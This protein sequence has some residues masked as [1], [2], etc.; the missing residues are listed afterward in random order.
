MLDRKRYIPALVIIIILFSF[1][2]RKR[3]IYDESI[4]WQIL[5]RYI[6]LTIVTV[7]S[8]A[9]HIKKAPKKIFS[10]I[11]LFYAFAFIS[12]LWSPN[13][14][15]SFAYLFGV[16]L[17]MVFIWTQLLI[18]KRDSLIYPDSIIISFFF[19]SIII[20]LV[21]YVGIVLIPDY[22]IWKD[23][24]LSFR[25]GGDLIH[26]NLL[27]AVAAFCIGF[28]LTF[29][30]YPLRKIKRISLLGLS[31]LTII[32]TQSRGALIAT[33]FALIYY[34]IK[35]KY[36]AKL[37][38]IGVFVVIVMFFYLDK[39]YEVFA[40]GQD[41]F[42]LT[43]RVYIW[44]LLFDDLSNIQDMIFGK[45]YAATRS[46]IVVTRFFTATHAHNLFISIFYQLGFIGSL[47]NFML[48]YRYC[49]MAKYNLMNSEFYLFN[50]IF[51][52]IYGIVANSYFQM[53][54]GYVS[55]MMIILFL[56]L[57]YTTFS[58]RK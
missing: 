10:Y 21:V 9:K 32:L 51:L 43:G 12:A 26:A 49:K 20:Q 47:I 5:L 33:I 53:Q 48:I 2:F 13:L 36:Y 29:R 1:S 19:A 45:G 7:I 15:I 23:G 57:S 18:V 4:D 37:L 27:G 17:F 31:S 25:L 58:L 34:M 42:L 46:G 39:I 3:E 14:L 55:M 22:V 40:R 56:T 41:I 52:L 30:E 44:S 16:I 28:L 35:Q 50:V 6:F 11:G 8:L 38:G 24:F 54:L